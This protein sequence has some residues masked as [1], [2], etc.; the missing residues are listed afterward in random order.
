M[1]KIHGGGIQKIQALKE[2]KEKGILNVERKSVNQK[3]K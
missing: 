1:R 2:K 3:Y